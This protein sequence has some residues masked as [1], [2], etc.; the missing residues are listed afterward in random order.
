MTNDRPTTGEGAIVVVVP[1]GLATR[2][3]I[4]RRIE[5]RT[6]ITLPSAILVTSTLGV[7]GSALE[8]CQN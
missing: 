2:F 8:H 6:E 5:F 3:D 4:A 7:H 1:V